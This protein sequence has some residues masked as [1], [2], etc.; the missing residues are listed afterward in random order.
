[1]AILVADV[2]AIQIPTTLGWEESYKMISQ[3]NVTKIIIYHPK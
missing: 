2:S 3:L 1:M